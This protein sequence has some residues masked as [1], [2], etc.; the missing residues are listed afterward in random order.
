MI[1]VHGLGYVGLATASLF[2]NGGHE[3]VGYDTSERVRDS[4]RRREPRVTEPDLREYVLDALD[5]NLRVS[6]TPVAADFHMVCVPTPY[7]A[8]RGK[9]D[10]GYVESAGETVGSVLR[11]G[12]VVVL[13]STVPPRTTL[14]VLTPMLEA[15][16]GLVA[17]EDFGVAFTPETVL[18][19]NT[20]AEMRTNDRI[21]GGIDV[22]SREAIKRLYASVIDADIL[23]APDAATAE[24]AKLA[25]NAYRDVNIAFA[26]EL[27]RIAADYDVDPRVAIE[28]A[29]HHPRVDVLNPG[30]GVGGHCLPVDPHFFR[31]DS[32]EVTLIDAARR[33]NDSMPDYVVDML[34]DELGGL[35]GKRVAV[36]GVAY[37]GN[38][39]DCRNSPGLAIARRLSQPIPAAV[40]A[41]TD[42][43]TDGRD[44]DVRLH[45]PYVTDDRVELEPLDE[46]LRGADGA[47]I[48]APHTEYTELDPAWVADLLADP[49]LVD[50]FGVLDV[51][52]WAE[53]GVRVV[54]Y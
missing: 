47:I 29:N 44:V 50:P 22:P 5:G 28:L 2:A 7:D 20:I 25:Q 38:V 26:N 3:V 12:D 31:E 9:A 42:G 21:V 23:E 13:E 24:F 6:D 33:V 52:R 4:L 17:G 49:V 53:G 11:A 18:P 14:D 35:S 15:E 40:S 16:S 34:S 51:Q 32:D 27:A 54:G 45:D 1:C 37:K 46:A 48:A 43:G 8:E 39:D 36:L 30:P 41:A 19:G 10:L